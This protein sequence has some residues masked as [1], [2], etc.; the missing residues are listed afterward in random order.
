MALPDSGAMIV[1]EAE[2]LDNL[3]DCCLS[4]GG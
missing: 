1:A 3:Y 2:S 4:H